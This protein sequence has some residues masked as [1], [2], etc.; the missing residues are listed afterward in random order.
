MRAY[1]N[2]YRVK[3]V[4]RDSNARE[5]KELSPFNWLIHPELTALLSFSSSHWL[6]RGLT[7]L[8]FPAAPSIVD[9]FRLVGSS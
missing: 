5:S 2:T 3:P 8:R 6:F 1:R 9:I 7:Q 4:Q